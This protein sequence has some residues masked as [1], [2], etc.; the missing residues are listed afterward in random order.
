V[1]N[2]SLARQ[3]ILVAKIKMMKLYIFAGRNEWMIF[4]IY[5][6]VPGRNQAIFHFLPASLSMPKIPLPRAPKHL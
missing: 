3:I 5:N 6:S 2:K 1:L 4:I